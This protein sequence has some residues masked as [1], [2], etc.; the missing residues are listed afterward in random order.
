MRLVTYLV[1]LLCGTACSNNIKDLVAHADPNADARPT[2][3]E[4]EEILKQEVATLDP[5][6]LSQ[7][8]L[9]AQKRDRSVA[10]LVTR[11]RELDPQA[12]AA[13]LPTDA[14]RKAFWIN[15]YNGFIQYVLR[16]K[17]ELYKDRG[18]FFKMKQLD[19]AGQSLSFDDIEHGIIRHGRAKLSAGYLPDLLDSDFEEMMA[20]SEVDPRIHFAVN[21]G[22]KDCPPVHL[23]DDATLDAQLDAL[24]R[25]YLAKT[26]VYDAEANTVKV[27]PLMNWFRGDFGGKNSSA[28]FLRAYEVIPQAGPK[29]KISYGDYDWTLA[30]DT[31][32]PSV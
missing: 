5:V 23:L 24:T 15:T 7:Q 16:N 8:F 30:L 14:A 18:E 26:T 10:A 25:Q 12:L 2:A 20:T 1:L 22:A 31:Y 4:A 28:S 21:C 17:P 27:T 29:P 32:A 3:V 13:A 11:Y 6:S 9:S 19:I